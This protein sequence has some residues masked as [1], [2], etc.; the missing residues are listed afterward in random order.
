[1]L[2]THLFVT[3]DHHLFWAG[4]RIHSLVIILNH[5]LGG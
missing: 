1:M 2:L 5:F 4:Y 3:F